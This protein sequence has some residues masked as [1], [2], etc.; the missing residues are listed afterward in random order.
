[1]EVGIAQGKIVGMPMI[2]NDTVMRRD[3]RIGE[4]ITVFSRMRLERAIIALNDRAP[5]SYLQIEAIPVASNQGG[6]S[7]K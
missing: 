4:D 1:M 7:F 3:H 5:L 6:R 2:R